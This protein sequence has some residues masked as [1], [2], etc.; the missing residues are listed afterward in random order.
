MEEK[1]VS[2]YQDGRLTCLTEVLAFLKMYTCTTWGLF[3]LL[4]VKLGTALSSLVGGHARAR[5]VNVRQRASKCSQTVRA[6]ACAY[7]RYKQQF[8]N[9]LFFF[10]LLYLSKEALEIVALDSERKQL[11]KKL[12]ALYYWP[13]CHFPAQSANPIAK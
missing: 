4:V 3:S 10:H 9:I 2:R 13:V 7:V 11:G 8:L 12:C 6:H 1:L 5:T